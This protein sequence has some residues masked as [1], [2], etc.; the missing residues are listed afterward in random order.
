MEKTKQTF[1]PTQYFLWVQN[2]KLAF[3]SEFWRC[4]FTVV[5]LA[6]FSLWGLLCSFFVPSYLLSLFALVAF[7]P[8]FKHFDQDMP[9]IFHHVSWSWGVC[10]PS[11]IYEYA[12]LITLFLVF[13]CA[14]PPLLLWPSYPYIMPLGD[15]PQLI[16]QCTFP[17]LSLS[18]FWLLF[19]V[20]VAI[21]SKSLI[22]SSVVTN[23]LL[24]PTGA[25]F[26]SDPGW[27]ELGVVGREPVHAAGGIRNV[28]G[29]GDIRDQPEIMGS[30]GISGRNRCRQKT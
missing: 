26:F 8:G 14:S 20:S 24:P 19:W 10:W 6:L 18:F 21:A 4:F 22:F 12:L 9:C 5:W 29:G 13:S 25:F 27:W 15:V 16:G 23:L 11:W 2:S 1:W 28:P 17:V 7:T 3:L 30:E